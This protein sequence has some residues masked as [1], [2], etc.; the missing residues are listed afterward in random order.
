[1]IEELRDEVYPRIDAFIVDSNAVIAAQ[2]RLKQQD[3][4]PSM[5][6][7]KLVTTEI[8][9]SL[10]AWI[11]NTI[12]DI[13][14]LKEMQRLEDVEYA[15]E[16]GSLHI[17]PVSG[18]A[19]SVLRRYEN[20]HVTVLDLW[21]EGPLTCCSTHRPLPELHLAVRQRIGAEELT[22]RIMGL[23]RVELN[24]RDALGRTPLF[25]AAQS[26]LY[27]VCDGLTP[28]PFAITWS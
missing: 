23:K 20:E 21:Q 24:S 7:K 9:S 3:V 22:K 16:A 6:M 25:C 10:E 27:E 8:D 18:L 4:T 13:E 15:K 28:T 5:V 14:Y 11:L 12:K 2:L 19:L 1:M 26:G 17:V